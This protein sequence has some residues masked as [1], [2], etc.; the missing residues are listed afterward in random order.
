MTH[1]ARPGIHSTGAAAHAPRST[2]PDTAPATVRGRGAS[3]A[4]ALGSLRRWLVAVLVAAAGPAVAS[5]PGADA[6]AEAVVTVPASPRVA[7]LDGFDADLVYAGMA[8]DV[9][10]HIVHL[11]ITKSSNGTALCMGALID[12]RY[13]LTAG[14]CLR[15]A[16]RVEAARRPSRGGPRQVVRVHGWTTHPQAAIDR[17]SR[18]RLPQPGARPDLRTVHLY[19][20]LG[21]ILLAEDFPGVDGSLPLA[22][23]HALRDWNAA[24][25]VIGYDR[26]RDT[27]ALTDRLSFIPLNRVHTIAGSGGAVLSGEVGVVFDHELKDVP[28]PAR[29]AYCQ[30]DSGAPVLAHLR[31][32]PAGSATPRHEIRLIGVSALGARPLPLLGRTRGRTAVGCFREVVWFSLTDVAARRWLDEAEAFLVRRHCP[33]AGQDPWC[34]PASRAPGR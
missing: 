14:H 20:D 31:T 33:A 4:A 29:L 26:D 6:A 7:A 30:G 16:L 9:R 18:T 21:L 23:P 5:A 12:R 13:V 34:G 3:I 15:G 8:I 25:A 28:R 27:R 22:E 32:H 19:R 10:R 11:R 2:S 1:L 24:A 17:G